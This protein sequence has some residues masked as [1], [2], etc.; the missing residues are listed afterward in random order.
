MKIVIVDAGLAFEV[1]VID[2]NGRRTR[3]FT[4]SNLQQACREAAA[5]SVAYGKLPFSA[6]QLEIG[7]NCSA[8]LVVPH[9]VNGPVILP[10]LGQFP[11]DLLPRCRSKY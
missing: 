8:C 4:Y 2:E 7:R 10:E 3:K 9:A 1:R 6:S 5:W 11:L